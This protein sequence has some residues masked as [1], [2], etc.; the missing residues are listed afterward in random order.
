[1][2]PEGHVIKNEIRDEINKVEEKHDIKLSTIQKILLS[3]NGPISTILDV[4][5]GTV[6]LFML[7]QHLEKSPKTSKIINIQ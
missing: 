1:M 4:L 2:I 5:Y 3:I 6:N 7:D